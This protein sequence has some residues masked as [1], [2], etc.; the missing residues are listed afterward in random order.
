MIP[1]DADGEYLFDPAEFLS[2]AA[3]FTCLA[4]YGA[5]LFWLAVWDA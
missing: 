2:A 5:A 4:V 3:T 1:F